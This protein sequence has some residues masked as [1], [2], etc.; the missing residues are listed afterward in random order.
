MA[1]KF[2]QKYLEGLDKN[3][4]YTDLSLPGLVFRVRGKYKNWVFVRYVDNKSYEIGLGGFPKTSLAVARQEA[5]RLKALSKREFLELIQEKKEKKTAKSE[6]QET[7]KESVLTFRDAAEKFVAWNIEVGNWK[8]WDKS[9]R[10]FESR[11][12]LHV[13]PIIGDIPLSEVK[14]SNVAEIAKTCWDKPATVDRCLRFTRQVFNWAKAKE[15]TTIDNPAER[16][17]AL[18]YLLPQQRHIPKNRGAISVRQLPELF[19][20]IYERFGKTAAGRCFLFAVLT[21]TRSG[22][23]RLAKWEQIDFE[24]MEWLIPP[25]QLKI[26]GNGSLIVPLSPLVIEFLKEWEPKE[27]GLIFFQRENKPLSDSIVSRLIKE[28]GDWIDEAQSVKTGKKVRPTLHGV[29]RAT[30]RTWAQD[31]SLE[32][33]KR[34]DPR[35]AELCLHHKVKDIYNGAYERNEHFK[36]RREMMDA[37]AEWCFSAL[38]KSE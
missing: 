33:D 28:S 34:F 20:T 15:L 31:D 6:K 35:I 7:E 12:R 11:M 30:F 26:A 21:A 16:S 22:T 10:V 13:L 29:S 24:K 25:E 23:A 18:Q 1:G 36:R 38:H 3:G 5:T 9:H 37:W 14:A 27:S 8:D 2:T 32:N 17:G 4:K 19:K